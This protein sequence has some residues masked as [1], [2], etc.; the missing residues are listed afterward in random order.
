MLHHT[1]I[2]VRIRA[3]IQATQQ[4]LPQLLMGNQILVPNAQHHFCRPT[5]FWC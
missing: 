5:E 4:L 1:S 3:R 2:P